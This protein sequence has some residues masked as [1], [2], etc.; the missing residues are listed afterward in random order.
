M[1]DFSFNYP[2]STYNLATTE[3]VDISCII[4][5]LPVN[6]TFSITP[7]LP[8]DL[9][10]D[11]S[12]GTIY[13]TTTFSSIS[14]ATNY[15]IDASYSTAVLSNSLTIS[16][17][18]LPVFNYPLTPYIV[19]IFS[20]VT[21]KPVYLIS[22]TL[23]IT[24]T[25]ISSPLL[26]D[27]SLNLNANNGNITGIPDVSSN[28]TPY[29]IRANNNGIIYDTTLT[30][31]VERPPTI[32]YPQSVYILEQGIEVIILPVETETYSNVTYEITG[33]ELPIGLFFD[34]DTGEI[35][36][37]PN[38]P[39]TYRNYQ[40]TIS[41]S[42][43]SATTSL[44]L[45]VIKKI[46]AP[47]VLADNFSSNTFLT[48][49]VIAMRRKAEILNYKKNSSNL[50]K[51]QY[52]ALLA[53]GNGPSAKR[54]WGTQGDAYTD[55]NI[56][57][58]PQ[59]GNTILCNSDQIICAPTSSSDVPGNVMQLC[60]NPA[61][62]VIGYNEPNQFRTY[63]GTKWPQTKWEPGNNGFPRGKAGR[64]LFFG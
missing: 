52:Y 51:Q 8:S 38:I 20:N 6:T 24:Y 50:T 61:V 39:T 46:I 4:V 17:N 26:S 35:S 1:P 7:S 43:G 41:N 53:K 60:Y 45:T 29:I 14:P 12:D 16:V 31:S 27:I 11:P 5:E 19:E 54:S 34:P 18:F 15:T 30:I 40:I 2:F 22:N 57:G 10:I 21:I 33:C 23:G 59:V 36:G 42:I 47:P 58:L 56:S 49:P 48:D 3:V 13:G 9:F 37:S 62:P 63:V 25:L 28:L 55:P 44:I 64:G 32:S